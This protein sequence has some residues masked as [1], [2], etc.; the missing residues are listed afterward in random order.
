MFSQ[1]VN[2]QDLSVRDHIVHEMWRGHCDKCNVHRI[3]DLQNSCVSLTGDSLKTLKNLMKWEKDLDK[4]FIIRTE[5][6]T[7]CTKHSLELPV[8]VADTALNRW[9]RQSK[10]N[11]KKALLEL[12]EKVKVKEVEVESMEEDDDDDDDDEDEYEEED[13]FW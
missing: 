13:D 10:F 3:H 11:V 8:Y 1:T 12:E 2:V 5:I 7:T 6:T 9:R 4:E